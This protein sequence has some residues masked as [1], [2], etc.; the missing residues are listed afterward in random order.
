MLVN[1][2]HASLPDLII[3]ERWPL[4]QLCTLKVGGEAEFFVAPDSFETMHLI[5]SIA[6][7]AGYPVY[8]IGGGSNVLFPDGLVHGVVLSTLKLNNINWRSDITADID[9]GFMLGALMRELRNRNLGSMEFAAGIPGTVGGAIMGNAGAGGHG[10]C[11][12]VDDVLVINSKGELHDLPISDVEYSYRKCSLADD[13]SIV[14]SARMTFREAK[15]KDKDI[16]ENY[17]LMRGLQPHALGNAGCTFKNPAG[18]ES[19]GKLLDE[20]GCKNLSVGGAI[21]SDLHANF[22]LNHGKAT[23]SDVIEL[24][25]ICQARVYDKTGIKLE[26]EIKI[27]ACKSE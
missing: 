24:I 27:L 13:D 1:K 21:V 26:P 25:K 12:L 4:S 8:V 6:R 11:E 18:F 15:P 17:M 5:V 9:A 2:L 3:Q 14:L 16:F 7:E 20:A 19:A 22:I 23:S 10:V